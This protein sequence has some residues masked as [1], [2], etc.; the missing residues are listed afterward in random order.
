[1]S[2]PMRV[3]CVSSRKLC[4]KRDLILVSKIDTLLLSIFVHH[5]PERNHEFAGAEIR[6]FV[7]T[8]HNGTTNF[9]EVT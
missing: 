9:S 4:F 7:I 1:M 2:Q 6:V 5:C 3:S 8:Y